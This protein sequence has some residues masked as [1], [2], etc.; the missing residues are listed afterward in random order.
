MTRSQ[1]QYARLLD[2]DRLIREGKYPNA[3]TYAAD[4]EVSQKTV[5]RDFQFLKW[6]LNAPLEYD[7]SHAGYYYTEKNWFLP[8]LKL[9]ENELRTLLL[10]ARAADAF[11]GTPLA[12]ELRGLFRK[13]ADLLPERL[14]FPP[15]MILNRFSFVSPAAKPIKPAFWAVLVNGLL[16]QQSVSIRYRSLNSGETSARLID[17]YHIAHL[18]GEWYVFAYCHKAKALRQFGLPQIQT[19]TLTTERFEVPGDFDA[20]KLLSRAFRRQ[21]LGDKTYAVRLLFDK[22]VAGRVTER[23]W[24]PRQRAKPRRNGDVELSFETPGLVEVA[25]WVLSWGPRVRVIQP[26]ELKHV[27]ANEIK[28]MAS[29]LEGRKR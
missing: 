7:R 8:A 4:R 12:D 6:S 20:E 14:S 9:S 19:V 13:L 27:V 11:H 24:H 22:S 21:V 29:S 5:Q 2:L 17:P 23:Q 15:E 28:K 26:L 18:H 25:R 10:T 3:K 16:T 1:S